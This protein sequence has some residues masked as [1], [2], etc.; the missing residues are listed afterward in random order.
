[1]ACACYWNDCRLYISAAFLA[2][3]TLERIDTFEYGSDERI[4]LVLQMI[5]Q[6]A[7]YDLRNCWK[8]WTR[9]GGIGCG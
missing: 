9:S 5:R 3:L 8:I 2:F 7:G 6:D 4:T 1:M